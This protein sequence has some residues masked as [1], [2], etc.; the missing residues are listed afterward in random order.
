MSISDIAQ[1]LGFSDMAH[2]SRYFRREKGMSPLAYRKR[3]LGQ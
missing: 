3:Y 1:A 2:I